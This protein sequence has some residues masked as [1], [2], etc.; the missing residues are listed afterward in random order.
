MRPRRV[1]K[2]K[3]SLS[4]SYGKNDMISDFKSKQID[5]IMLFNSKVSSMSCCGRAV[6]D[7]ASIL[8]QCCSNT[9]K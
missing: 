4:L 9:I 1:P 8:N 3:P 7:R 6:R 2:R 5:D